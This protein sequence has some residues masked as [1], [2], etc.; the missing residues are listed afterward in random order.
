MLCLSIGR[1]ETALSTSS[2]RHQKN[3][4]QA[5]TRTKNKTDNDRGNRIGLGLA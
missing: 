3:L 1:S 5:T 2:V 4:P